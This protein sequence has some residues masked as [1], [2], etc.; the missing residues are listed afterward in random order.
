M[1]IFPPSS[2]ILLPFLFFILLVM[3]SAFAEHFFCAA[4]GAAFL[5]ARHAPA[6][7]DFCSAAR[8]DAVIAQSGMVVV[9]LVVVM[10]VV[11]VMF[12][13]VMT[14]AASAAPMLS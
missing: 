7:D 12:V 9:M 13:V 4:I 2:L 1:K 6:M 8:A 3:R 14:V 10:L 5:L 11:V